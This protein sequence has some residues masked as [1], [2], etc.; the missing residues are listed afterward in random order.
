MSKKIIVIED[1][2]DILDLM[3][4]ILE[5]EGYQVIASNYAGPLS[6]IIK[7]KP[8]LILL[9]DRLRD[10]SGRA[11]CAEIKSR[12]D[13]THI[14]V[15]LVSATT[16]LAKVA[17]ESKANTYLTKPFNISDLISVVKKLA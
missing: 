11:L 12:P 15:V 7:H 6:D 8:N 5:G 10:G 3:Q 14:P 13:T 9:D 16:D 1:D 17:Q 2:N 4:Y